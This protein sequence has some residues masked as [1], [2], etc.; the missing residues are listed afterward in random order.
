MSTTQWLQQKHVP[1]PR[2]TTKRRKTFACLQF[3]L[4]M[5][6]YMFND[7]GVAFIGCF[8]LSRGYGL[9]L[10]ELP[11]LYSTTTTAFASYFEVTGRWLRMGAGFLQGVCYGLR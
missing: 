2:T 5:V 11:S 8:I 1:T 4:T 9:A 10:V 6:E 3:V 7:L